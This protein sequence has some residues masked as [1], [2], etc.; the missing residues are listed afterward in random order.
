MIAL[1]QL[2][3]L[4]PCRPPQFTW[5]ALSVGTR[6]EVVASL[7]RPL[8]S[9]RSDVTETLVTFDTSDPIG[10]GATATTDGHG[11]TATAT[12]DGYEATATILITQWLMHFAGHDLIH[13]RVEGAKQDFSS[14]QL[15][16]VLGL[17][18]LVCMYTRTFHM[19]FDHVDVEALPI[20]PFAV[21]TLA[22]V[23]RFDLSYPQDPVLIIRW[24]THFAGHDSLEIF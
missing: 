14:C 18:S 20:R 13:H 16:P 17:T 3:W 2:T 4:V 15:W 24:Y 23:A 11:T 12:T 1:A 5:L 21:F 19:R 9:Q 10:Y 8:H 6:G 22:D 7:A